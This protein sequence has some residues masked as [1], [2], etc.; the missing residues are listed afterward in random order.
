MPTLAPRIVP[1]IATLLVPLTA[2]LVVHVVRATPMQ[3][4]LI[5][6]LAHKAYSKLWPL[7]LSS[8]HPY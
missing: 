7:I 6:Q 8:P 5:F 3:V 1:L 2:T 4:Q